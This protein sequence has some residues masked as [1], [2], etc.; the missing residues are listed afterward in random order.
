MEGRL[1]EEKKKK[2]KKGEETKQSQSEIEELR[3]EMEE[4]EERWLEDR[5]NLKEELLK[6]QSLL[7]AQKEENH[8]LRGEV[9]RLERIQTLSKDQDEFGEDGE[10]DIDVIDMKGKEMLKLIHKAK[11]L[12]K[13]VKASERIKQEEEEKNQGT[14]G[15]EMVSPQTRRRGRQ[16]EETLMLSQISPIYDPTTPLSTLKSPELGQNMENENE[17]ESPPRGW[18]AEKKKMI[19]KL[20]RQAKL[21]KGYDVEV[22]RMRKEMERI[23]IQRTRE[24]LSRAASLS[25]ELKDHYVVDHSEEQE[26]E[27]DKRRVVFDQDD[28]E[29]LEM[30]CE[31]WREKC[32]DQG[33][34]LKKLK[35]VLE[36]VK[37][38]IENAGVISEDTLERMKGV[39][40]SLG[41]VGAMSDEGM[42][43]FIEAEKDKNGSIESSM[44]E[45][46]EDKLP[47]EDEEQLDRR[48][49]QNNDFKPDQEVDEEELQVEEKKDYGDGL[50]RELLNEMDGHVVEAIFHSIFDWYASPSHYIAPAELSSNL[51]RNQDMAFYNH[52]QTLRSSERDIRKEQEEAIDVILLSKFRRFVRE[53]QIDQFNLPSSISDYDFDHQEERKIGS[54]LP[55][56][57]LF[58]MGDADVIFKVI[59]N[60]DFIFN[61]F[62]CLLLYCIEINN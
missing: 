3:S 12:A 44:P 11:T 50:M 26:D 33:I 9:E 13:Q 5:S 20:K 14:E 21:I 45:D 4:R 61:G 39:E 62:I 34:L 28:I 19:Q 43:A 40:I 27:E 35:G 7:D 23:K 24:R 59:V 36:G 37:E 41:C 48:S 57:K 6:A 2:D 25:S 60:Y 42:K 1:E 38:G 47:R 52:S 51:K 46:E 8:L 49:D 53:F 31:E 29:D 18:R 58:C 17:N 32:M 54:P 56:E 22:D 16:N 10:D 30:E 15:E 55:N